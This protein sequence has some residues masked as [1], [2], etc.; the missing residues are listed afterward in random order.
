MRGECGEA[1]GVQTGGGGGGG[2]VPGPGLLATG[3]GAGAAVGDAPGLHTAVGRGKL[4]R[5]GFE[6]TWRGPGKILGRMTTEKYLG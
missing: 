5:Y 2:G 1:A 4:L 3:A 6:K